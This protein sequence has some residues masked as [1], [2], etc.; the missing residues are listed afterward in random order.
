MVDIPRKTPA[1]WR[2]TKQ[3][4]Y[5]AVVLGAVGG[6]SWYISQLEPAAPSVDLDQV[7]N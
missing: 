2:L 3:I 4:L 6:I 5:A 7:W 1:R